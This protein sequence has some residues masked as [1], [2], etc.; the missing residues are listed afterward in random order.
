[1]IGLLLVVALQDT[2]RLTMTDAVNRAL[3]RYPSVAAARAAQLGANADIRQAQAQRLPRIALD[4]SATQ[5][6]LPGLVYPLHGLPTGPTSPQ[7]VFDKTLYQGSA[8][9][10]WTFFDFGA[11]G[12]RADASR[13]LAGAAD[14]ALSSA[15]ENLTARTANAYLRVLTARGV[16]A[17]QDQRLA[18]L[19]A[20][21]ARTRR[22]L[23]E[24]KAARVEVLRAE[25]TLARARADRSGTAGQ[26][27]VAEHELA[28]LAGMPYDDVTRAALPGE[29]L[30]DTSD[31]APL[32][33]G[34]ARIAL[35]EQAQAANTDVLEVRRRAQAAEAVSA[36]ARA[37]RLPE[38]RLQA[39]IVDRGAPGD[40]QKAEWQAGLGVSYPLYTGGSRA[41]QID[42]AAAD[43]RGAAEQVRLA[44]LAAASSVD[45]A[46]ASV[47]E[48]R[49]RVLALKSA[50]E[51]SDAVVQVERTSL[52]VG[53]GTQTDYLDALS[54]LFQA[55]SSLIEAA[56][57]EIAAHIELA[58]VTGA[59]SPDWLAQHLESTR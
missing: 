59:L 6:Q 36:S 45:R 42:R 54:Q 15:Q 21:T 24:G 11:R 46:V 23:A 58:R 53:S 14:A 19:D 4:A 55:R 38:L 9:L 52:D 51:T 31:P 8:L 7:P 18:A 27:D 25:A 30:A 44:E 48:S 35:A 1:M 40:P 50:V 49:A 12:A 13:A 33:T 47:I 37:T 2:S 57:A 17:A 43:A 41:G 34:A 3:G 32:V 29:V 5:N 56:H 26:L 20:E 28:Q 39:G 16:L 22:L 10:N